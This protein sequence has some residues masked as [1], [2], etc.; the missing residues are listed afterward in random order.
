M[1]KIIKDSLLEYYRLNEGVAKQQKASHPWNE[2]IS[3]AVYTA[4]ADVRLPAALLGAP[5]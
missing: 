3:W 1:S 5:C 4:A 2:I